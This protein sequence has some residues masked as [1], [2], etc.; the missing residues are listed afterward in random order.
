MSESSGDF[1]ITPNIGLYKPNYNADVGS[2]GLH[3]NA[4]ADAIDTILGNSAT[5]GPYLPTAGGTMRG[6]ITLAAQ[7]TDTMH[8]ANKQYVDTMAASGVAGVQSF[9]TRT[10]VITL[11]AGDV[12]AVV[13]PAATAPPMDGVGA[14]GTGVA[15]AR[16]DH[17]HPSDTSRAATA[18]PTFTGTVTAPVVNATTVHET[19]VAMAA[20]NIDCATGSFFTRTIAG[21]TT[22]TVSNVPAAPLVPSFVLELTNGGA[23]VITWWAGVRWAGG[24]PPTLTTAGIDALGFYTLDGGANWRGMLLAKAFA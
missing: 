3:L 21:A 20:S 9:N 15:W 6:F 1:T 12:T 19:V 11:T 16:T 23:G 17:Q 14:V 8:A 10:G 24:L 22:L 4:N 5:A 13:P 2:W 7:P 18:S